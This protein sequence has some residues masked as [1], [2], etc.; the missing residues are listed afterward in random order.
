MLNPL[1]MKQNMI[2]NAIDDVKSGNQDQKIKGLKFLGATIGV[3]EDFG[4]K[5][6]AVNVIE[7]CLSDK[8]RRIRKTA[9]KALQLINKRTPPSLFDNFQGGVGF[10]S[11]KKK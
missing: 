9:E 2:K 7:G 4:L 3:S 1:E 10:S 11:K 5:T 6:T 8:N